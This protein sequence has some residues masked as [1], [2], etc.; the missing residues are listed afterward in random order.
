MIRPRHFSGG[1]TPERTRYS[2]L[3]AVMGYGYETCSVHADDPS[4]AHPQ[5]RGAAQIMVAVVAALLTLT[6]FIAVVKG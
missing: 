4:G 3:C 2:D 1:M 5:Y 6:A